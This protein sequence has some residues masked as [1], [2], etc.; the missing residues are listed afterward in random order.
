LE[1]EVKVLLGS[2][3]VVQRKKICRGLYVETKRAINSEWG[4]ILRDVATNKWQVKT[5]DGRLLEFSSQQLRIIDQDGS[6]PPEGED[7][8]IVSDTP[9]TS[10]ATTS[11]GDGTIPPPPNSIIN[12]GAPIKNPAAKPT[13]PPVLPTI[14][15]STPASI[16]SG[17]TAAPSRNAT[18]NNN[19][20]RTPTLATNYSRANESS[21]T[22]PIDTSS[23]VS[24]DLSADVT[25]ESENV[26]SGNTNSGDLS[27]VGGNTIEEE[28]ADM[29]DIT[30]AGVVG[31]EHAAFME[32]PDDD[33][34]MDQYQQRRMMASI[35]KEALIQS[36]HTVAVGNPSTTGEYTWKVVR[37]SFPSDVN[38]DRDHDAIGLKGV[39]FN[40]LLETWDEWS[41]HEE[42][43]G[44]EL[45]DTTIDMA[46]N[47]PTPFL[48]VF[49]ALEALPAHVCVANMN[50]RLEE[51]NKKNKVQKKRLIKL[52]TLKEW[53]H[54]LLVQP[55]LGEF[56]VSSNLQARILVSQS[57]LPTSSGTTSH[58]LNLQEIASKI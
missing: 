37:E 23:T 54:F 4:I 45:G 48:E 40:Q 18:I 35:A 30:L 15:E 43:K 58:C 16:S 1:D 47:P 57:V 3:M 44:F 41:G 28:S 49:M 22:T 27:V 42:E 36:G 9:A 13:T 14:D 8:I 5:S 32:T 46:S 10:S 12:N 26:A 24:S 11:S 6:H 53:W 17:T 20:A 25:A 52:V 50:R 38:S 55:R 51:V 29:E 56:L 2:N 33:V 21:T 39:D 31:A 7:P 34:E 19:D